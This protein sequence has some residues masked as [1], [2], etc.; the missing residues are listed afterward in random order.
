MDLDTLYEKRSNLF[1]KLVQ[2][3]L[4][5]TA[6]LISSLEF[7]KNKR[8]KIAI[9]SSGTKEYI[10][11]VLNKYDI[12]QYFNI[13]VSGD[14]VKVGKPNPE[15]YIVAAKKLGFKPK[16]CLV[17]EDATVGIKSAKSAGCICIAVKNPKTPPQDYSEADLVINSLEEIDENIIN[18]LKQS[19][20]Y[21]CS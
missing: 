17:L 2:D 9:A 1:L 3:K 14:N 5:P 13:I 7:F 18:S 21:K 12:S 19:Q 4:T 6:G 16:E 11:L 20:H 10:H 8:M 15:T